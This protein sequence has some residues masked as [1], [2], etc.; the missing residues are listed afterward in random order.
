[1]F[2]E[3]LA[4]AREVGRV[5]VERWEG[6]FARMVEEAGGSAVR[7]VGLLEEE[8][9]SFRDRASYGGREVVFLK[10]AQICAVDL[11]GTFGG[12]GWG[13]FRDLG[14]LTAFA[15]YKI[16][17]VLRA[18]GVLVYGPELAAA[19]D[20]RE[21]IPAGDPREV[22]IRACMVW[23]VEWIRRELAARGQEK[24]PYEI[25][26]HLWNLGQQRLPGERPYHRT[27]TIF[28]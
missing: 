20:A 5:L 21:E 9:P 11:S 6:S 16:P 4:N 15:D 27:R 22:E 12:R 18:L 1:M 3:R 28:Y 13:A 2:R 26:W 25:D 8:L 10:R 14:R 19:V 17:Q 7:L 24:L 23:A